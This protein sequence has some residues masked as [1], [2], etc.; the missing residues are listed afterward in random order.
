MFRD[1]VDAG[2]R[3]AQALRAHV[4]EDAI[5][6]ALPRGGVPVG[7]EVARALG[8]PLDVVI[9]RKLGCPWQPELGIGAVSEGGIRL[10]NTSLIA[11][12]GVTPEEVEVVSRRETAELDRRVR[13]Y[14]GD[15]DPL[16]V[17]DRTVLLV[18]DGLAT[19]FTARAAIDVLRH[20]G[21]ARIVLAVPVAPQR[22]LDEL[23]RVADD[24]VCLEVPRTFWGVGGAYVDFSQTSDDEVVALLASAAGDRD[25]PTSQVAPTSAAPDPEVTVRVEGVDLSGA[26]AV[27][28]SAVGLVV[29]AHGSGSSRMSPR[30]RA[31]AQ[32][33]QE[34]G[35]ATLVFD[36]LTP[37]EARQRANVFDIGLLGHRLAEVVRWTRTRPEVAD[38]PV[39]L[40]GSSTGAAAALVAA[41]EPGS[42]V[43]AVVS[44]GGR[45][46]LAG[47]ALASVT[48]PTLLIV[49]GRDDVVRELNE[50]AA[51]AL[52]C[53]YE[54]SVV[55]GA[56]HL[57]EE[58][59]ALARV[60][61]LAR[62]W[63]LDHLA[64]G[65]P[66]SVVQGW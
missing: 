57:F 50:T 32:V 43:A 37:T 48:A 51:R 16:E 64:V 28:P 62:E 24:V 56:T 4:D 12:S 18:D 55:P 33:L 6:V 59:G 19:G 65:V 45:P 17:R 9:V 36:L 13:R 35:L 22:T 31:V 14:R 42:V 60:A 58:P 46:D 44:R 27:P 52:R 61:S 1:R 49:G 40:F 47:R 39:G 53:P 11:E 41:A 66:D 63:F 30:N 54:L 38:L 5:V 15:R 21:A 34:G 20:R 26:L 7:H 2:R 3:L 10:L 23:A 29:F 25:G 8:M